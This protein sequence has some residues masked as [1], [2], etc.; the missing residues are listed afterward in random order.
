MAKPAHIELPTGEQIRIL[1]EDRSVLAIDKPPG[2]LLAP[3]SWQRTARNLQAALVSSLRAGDFWARSRNLKY[4]RFVHRLDA[5]TSGV[6]LLAKSPGAL[7][8]C[9]A[10]FQTRAVEKIY[11]A[12]VRGAPS[13]REWTAHDPLGEAPGRRGRMRI[14][15]RA[16]K[17]AE[18]H[19]RVLQIRGGQ[20]LLR[21]APRTGRTHQIRVHLAAAR[22]PVLGD[23][24]YGG[25]A[26]S[27]SGTAL[28]DR[29]FQALALRAVELGYVDPF[30]RGP[31]RI[32]A[33]FEAFVHEFGFDIPEL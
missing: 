2:W 11:L 24:L 1:H 3:E 29:G 14:D 20:A 8:A 28:R 25:G 12:V 27:N 10:L 31:V 7:R 4:V 26:E 22:L 19:F 9:G 13:R 5:E 32:R 17:A 30:T 18:T 21:A 15:R 16:G 6:L 33:P 23:A